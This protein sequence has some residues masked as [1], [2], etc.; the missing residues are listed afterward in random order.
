MEHNTRLD[1]MRHLSDQMELNMQ[2][3]N[4]NQMRRHVDYYQG[5]PYVENPMYVD[6]IKE[7][8][9]QP[10]MERHPTP[11]VHGSIWVP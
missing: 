3:Y 1:R 6:Y 10:S 8:P 2:A 11:H 9:Y 5:V 4:E 7:S